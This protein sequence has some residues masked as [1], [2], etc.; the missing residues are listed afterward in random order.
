MKENIN[1]ITSVGS[2]VLPSLHGEK[3]VW[4]CCRQRSQSYDVSNKFQLFL[5][6][7]D[8]SRAVIQRP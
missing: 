6:D 3:F 5:V 1:N 7:L 2:Q 8:E 4:M